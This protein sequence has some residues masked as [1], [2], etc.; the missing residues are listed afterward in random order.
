M[1]L[2]SFSDKEQVDRRVNHMSSMSEEES[3]FPEGELT[4]MLRD[5][6]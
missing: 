6:Q 2:D 5:H 4:G 1:T 3:W